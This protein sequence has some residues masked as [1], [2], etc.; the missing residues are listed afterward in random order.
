MKI[1]LWRGYHEE[2]FALLVACALE[3]GCLLIACPPG[4]EDFSFLGQ[5]PAGT[6][7]LAGDWASHSAP[8]RSGL[9]EFPVNVCLGVFTS[10]TTESAKLILYSR[11]NVASCARAIFALFDRSRIQSVFCYP[12]PFHT[13][14]LTLGY[15]SAHLYGWRLIAP[16][17]KYSREHHVAWL[18]DTGQG[19]V[20]LGT[21]TH[22]IDLAAHI[23]GVTPSRSYAA[24]AGGAR[25]S[26]ELWLK[27]RDTLNIEAPSIGYGA[28]EASPGV[29][30]LS[31]GV[32][33]SEDGEVGQPLS[34]LRVAVDPLTGVTF[35]GPS[36]CA[37]I[38]QRG[39]LEFPQE[40]T[41]PD[42]MSVRGDGSWVFQGR[43][44]FTLNRG[45]RKI[46]LE[47]VEGEVRLAF[48]VEALGYCVP[49]SR[50]GEELGLLLLTSPERIDREKWLEHLKEKFGMSF[51]GAEL[52]AVS[53]FPLSANM[54]PDR[55]SALTWS[56]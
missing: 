5:L 32:E 1:V 31:P 16:G 12:Q 15:A 13:F 41:L 4:H 6:V 46:L 44:Q 19:T 28:S 34:H 11:E 25:V 55:R 53:R 47:A 9:A 20:T 54:K 18:R 35:S 38:V 14:G 23:R 50:L 10:G 22:F 48:G 45:G 40:F 26:R 3:G 24:I 52:R 21:P 30:H 37:A 36:L 27:M 29:T 7:E 33:P 49:D 39:I 8:Q 56:G 17:G 51:A 2:G 42:L 43:A